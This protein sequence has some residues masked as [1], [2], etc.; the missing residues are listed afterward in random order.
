MFFILLCLELGRLAATT[1][2]ILPRSRGDGRTRRHRRDRIALSGVLV[3]QDGVQTNHKD[4]MTAG[5]RQAPT[6]AGRDRPAVPRQP[7]GRWGWL[8]WVGRDSARAVAPG[9]LV[10][11]RVR[12][13]AGS[14]PQ[15][16]QSS[17]TWTC[18]SR[19]KKTDFRDRRPPAGVH[20]NAWTA[21]AAA[22]HSA[23]HVCW[24]K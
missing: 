22:R 17:W 16:S 7:P 23:C 10:G 12:L 15:L 3:G 24:Q 21:R 20:I 19:T 14:Q 1:A 2:A 9:R 11:G 13:F 6:H 18:T 8:G 5:R 4:A